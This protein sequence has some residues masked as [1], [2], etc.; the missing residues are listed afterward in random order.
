MEEGLLWQAV[1]RAWPTH[2]CSVAERRG[3]VIGIAPM[4]GDVQSDRL[5]EHTAT[6]GTRNGKVAVGGVEHAGA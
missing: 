4:A 6:A 5:G 1:M 2:I 3:I